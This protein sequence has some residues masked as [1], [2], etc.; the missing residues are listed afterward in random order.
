MHHE[1]AVAY[2]SVEDEF[3]VVWHSDG[4]SAGIAGYILVVRPDGRR[5]EEARDDGRA[6]FE[7][8]VARSHAMGQIFQLVETLAEKIAGIVIDEFGVA[9][10]RVKVNKPGA[11]RGARDVGVIIERGSRPTPE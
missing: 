9:W 6:P 5:G 2:N 8:M 7:G 3:L 1:P 11:I 4:A 10:V